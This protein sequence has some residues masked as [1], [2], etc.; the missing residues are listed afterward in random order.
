MPSHVST[1]GS[2]QHD[3]VMPRT[4]AE[5][6]VNDLRRAILAGEYPAGTRLRQAEIAA[7]YSVSTTPVRAA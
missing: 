2:D 3:P 5:A 6:I 1:N 7:R 4:R